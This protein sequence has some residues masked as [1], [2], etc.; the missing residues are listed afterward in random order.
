MTSELQLHFAT[1]NAYRGERLAALE[2]DVR[3]TVEE[4]EETL[5]G[6]YCTHKVAV[7]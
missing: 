2:A 4:L 1:R 6:A 7:Q 5:R 3:H